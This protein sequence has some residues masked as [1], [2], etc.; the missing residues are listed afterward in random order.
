MYEDEKDALF[1]LY[2]KKEEI[3]HNEK[4]YELLGQFESMNALLDNTF[5]NNTQFRDV[6]MDDDT[7]LL[8]QD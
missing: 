4:E 3:N 8:G 6:I 1:S 2:H 5:L 7:E